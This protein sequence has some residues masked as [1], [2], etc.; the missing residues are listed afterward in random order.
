[1]Q[2]AAFDGHLC[3]IGLTHGII[4]S[5]GDVADAVGPNNTGAYGTVA[6]ESPVSDPDLEQL[7]AP[8]VSRDAAVIEFDLVP[9]GDTLIMWSVFA[10]EE[11]PEANPVV[12]DVMGVF[13]SGPGI[14]GP[15]TN[16][17][18]NIAVFVVDTGLVSVMTTT[19]N[20]ESNPDL[21][22]PN[23]NGTTAPQDGDPYFVQYDGFSI[24]LRF[25]SVV[26]PGVSYHMKIA[27]A[28]AADKIYDSS[29]FLAGGSLTTGSFALGSNAP[30]D[31]RQDVRFEYYPD[32]ALIQVAGVAKSDHA[33]VVLMDVAGRIVKKQRM[34]HGAS[35]L[36][37]QG[38]ARGPYVLVVQS[39]PARSAFRFVV[40]R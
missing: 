33:D 24:P 13:L 25:S 36:S 11:Y 14:S 40:D 23:G 22:V 20:D 5:N 38:L 39:G 10:S 19:I 16:D 2:F 21:Y 8:Q 9:Y 35:A 15:F 6:S 1:M 32:A 29:V 28:D 30:S 37:T 31:A 3:N 26:E 4:L 17:A 27:I 12:S 7:I 34:V 18:V